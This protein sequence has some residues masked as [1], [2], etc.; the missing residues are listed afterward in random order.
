M[1]EKEWDRL[2]DTNPGD[3]DLRL[4]YAIWLQ[5]ETD[6]LARAEFHRWL[7]EQQKW[8]TNRPINHDEKGWSWYWSY[9]PRDPA[10]HA[11]LGQWALKHMPRRRWL[12]RTRRAAEDTLYE[13]WR[14]W[15]AGDSPQPEK[16]KPQRKRKV[17]S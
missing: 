3:G 4:A 6:D 10:K 15:R 13:A 1:T 9:Q 12:Y 7:I 14:S 8:P 17:Q 16:K 11:T 2:L 5:D